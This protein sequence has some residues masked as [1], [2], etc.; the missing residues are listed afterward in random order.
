MDIFR[1]IKKGIKIYPQELIP[2]IL[3]PEKEIVILFQGR[4]KIGERQ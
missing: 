4:F 1:G 3:K 2:Y